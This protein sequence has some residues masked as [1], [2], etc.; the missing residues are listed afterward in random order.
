MTSKRAAI[1]RWVKFNTVGAIGIGVQLAAL[2]FLKSALG[3]NY[4]V[5]TA[6]AVEAT[7]VHNFIWH[8]RYTWADRKNKAPL[9][10]FLRFNVSNG[11]ISILGNLALMRLLAGTLA[12]N[13]FVANLLSIAGCS[14]LNFLVSDSFVFRLPGR[15]QSI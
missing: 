9:Q 15:S 4:L 1:V 10:T 13:Y 14:I 5:A 7:V 11:L 12:I 2:T 3:L 6:L 8:E